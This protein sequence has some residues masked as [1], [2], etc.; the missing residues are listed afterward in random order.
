MINIEIIINNDDSRRD[1][2]LESLTNWSLKS[3]SI[4][5][6]KILTL[7]TSF[8]VQCLKLIWNQL[9]VSVFLCIFQLQMEISNVKV[10][11]SR[12]DRQL[13]NWSVMNGQDWDLTEIVVVGRFHWKSLAKLNVWNCRKSWCPLINGT[14]YRIETWQKVI[15]LE[16]VVVGWFLWKSLNCIYLV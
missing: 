3:L 9:K 15:C 5:I 14:D 13:T 6:N 1:D 7:L 4:A 12:K 10:R 2:H 16:I 8:W 11:H